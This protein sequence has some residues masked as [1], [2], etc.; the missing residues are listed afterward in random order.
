VKYTRGIAILAHIVAAS[1]LTPTSAEDLSQQTG[2][3]LYQRL[4]AACHGDNGKGDGH[5]RGLLQDA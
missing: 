1:W 4:C 2:N 5:R 3:E